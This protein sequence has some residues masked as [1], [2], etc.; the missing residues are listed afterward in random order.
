MAVW[1]RLIDAEG[2]QVDVN[3]EQV[4]FMVDHRDYTSIYFAGNG[5]DLSIDVK[6]RLDEIHRAAPLRSADQAGMHIK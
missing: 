1:K 2:R 6:Q 5:E 3:M 4:C